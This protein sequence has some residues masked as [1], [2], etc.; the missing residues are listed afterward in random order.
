MAAYPAFQAYFR[1]YQPPLLAVW[2]QHDP[3][4]IA[5]GAQAYRKDLPKAQVHLPGTGHFALE[6]HAV[7]IA[8][9]ISDFSRAYAQGGGITRSVCIRNADAATRMRAGA[10]CRAIGP[11][12]LL[13]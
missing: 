1:T 3:A 5:A 6:T 11:A 10:D 13:G 9:Y 12:S 7:Q 8:D 2:G 4:V